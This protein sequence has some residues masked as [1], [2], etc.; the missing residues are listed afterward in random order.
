MRGTF[1]K[2]L[3]MGILLLAFG[4]RTPRPNLKPPTQAEVLSTPPAERRFNSS[5]YPKEA[6][7]DRNAIKKIDDEPITPT[8]GKSINSPGR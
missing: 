5:D 1:A 7:V 4:C 3:G 8:M 6:F 2:V